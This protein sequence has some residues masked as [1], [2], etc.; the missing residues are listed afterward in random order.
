MSPTNTQGN[1]IPHSKKSYVFVVIMFLY[2]ALMITVGL[3]GYFGNVLNE[4]MSNLTETAENQAAYAHM[5]S[6][7]LLLLSPTLILYIAARSPFN[8]PRSAR[9]I[10]FILTAIVLLA[11]Q[12]IYMQQFQAI[13]SEMESSSSGFSEFALGFCYLIGAGIFIIFYGISLFGGKI[14]ARGGPLAKIMKNNFVLLVVTVLLT[15]FLFFFSTVIMVVCMAGIIICCLLM[16][17]GWTR[18]GSKKT[19]TVWEVYED[20]F[21]RY[22]RQTGFTF[23]NGVQ[24]ARYVDDIGHYWISV[25]NGEHFI[26]ESNLK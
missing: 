18:G 25:D 19:E 12:A 7:F 15:Y 1:Q 20:G 14:L 4:L 8:L 21:K 26:R 5:F 16:F 22:L 17:F 2:Y 13:Y 10:I 23:I 3:M 6:L 11:F 24:C 9:I